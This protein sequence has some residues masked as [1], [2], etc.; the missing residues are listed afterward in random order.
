MSDQSE[1]SA[2]SDR[3]S[4]SAASADVSPRSAFAAALNLADAGETK[5]TNQPT[6]HDLLDAINPLQHIP[7][8][9]WLY[10]Q[11]SGDQI[12]AQARIAGDAIYGGIAGLVSGMFNALV[13]KDTGKDVAGNIVAFI[14]GKSSAPTATA[15]AAPA[16]P[17]AGSTTASGTAAATPTAIAATPATATLASSAPATP[18]ATANTA[19]NLPSSAPPQTAQPLSPDSQAALAKLAADLHATSANPTANPPTAPQSPAPQQPAAQPLSAGSQ[20][21]LARLAADLHTAHAAGVTP[22]SFM[23]A[24]NAVP[25]VATTANGTP[26]P[27][28]PVLAA[29]AGG[30]NGSPSGL[31]LMDY[32]NRPVAEATMPPQPTPTPAGVNPSQ[33][34]AS[35]AQALELSRQ[36]QNY[37]QGGPAAAPAAADAAAP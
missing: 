18:P 29:R 34:A 14:T 10:R 3:R 7:V 27:A 13:E 19:P 37:Y 9:S 30:N 8:V 17:T 36:I 6:F 20:A 35:Y 16:S 26:L 24:A 25:A 31:S 15:A 4:F 32:R 33:A 11:I 21:A 23:G 2:I 12:S 5:A 28:R 1:T 22:A